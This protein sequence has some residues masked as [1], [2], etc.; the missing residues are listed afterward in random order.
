V[1]PSAR[2]YSGVGSLLFDQGDFA[3]SAM[4]FE[5]AVELEPRRA[6]AYRN[7]GDAYERLGET[8]KARQVWGEAVR[9]GNEDLQVN[10]RDANT[11]AMVAVCEMKLGRSREAEAHATQAVEAAPKDGEV[12]YRVAA[13]YAIAGRP[14]QALPVLE[15]AIEAGYSPAQAKKDYDLRTLRPLPEFQDLVN[16]P[17]R[18]PS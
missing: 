6:L 14:R 4:A 11:Q 1:S 7:L 8:D 17:R 12:L 16:R 15:R 10:A 13:V 2:A 3:K 18:G 9:L 5:K